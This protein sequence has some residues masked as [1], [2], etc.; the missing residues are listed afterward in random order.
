MVVGDFGNCLGMPSCKRVVE[1]LLG[2]IVGFKTVSEIF[3]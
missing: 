1:I 2:G 3:H